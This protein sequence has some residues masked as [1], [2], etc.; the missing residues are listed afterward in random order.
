MPDQKKGIEMNYYICEHCGYKY[1]E[2]DYCPNCKRIPFIRPNVF[3]AEAVL[4]M[5]LERE[6]QKKSILE[7]KYY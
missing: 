4:Q 1:A 3:L 2:M 5:D 7:I 6:R